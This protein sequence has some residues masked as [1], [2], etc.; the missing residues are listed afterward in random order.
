ML[1]HLREL[2]EEFSARAQVEFGAALDEGP[3]EHWEATHRA[4]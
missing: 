4:E 2:E 1:S 3:E